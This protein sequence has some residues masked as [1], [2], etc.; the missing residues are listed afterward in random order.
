MIVSTHSNDILINFPIQKP[1]FPL[2]LT[3]HYEDSFSLWSLVWKFHWSRIDSISLHCDY[4]LAYFERFELVT[5]FEKYLLHF[6]HQTLNIVNEGLHGLNYFPSSLVIRF[7]RNCSRYHNADHT[8]T[9][10][11]LTYLSTWLSK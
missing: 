10:I 5:V 6:R 7:S 4:V 9:N 8:L 1:P 3:W 11:N 2:I